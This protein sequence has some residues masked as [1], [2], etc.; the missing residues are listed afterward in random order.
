MVVGSCCCSVVVED[1]ASMVWLDL[2]FLLHSCCV[3]A[4]STEDGDRGVGSI[5]SRR[6]F[7]RGKGNHRCSKKE[8]LVYMKERVNDIMTTALSPLLHSN[9]GGDG[10]SGNSGN[11]SIS[12]GNSGGGDSDEQSGEHAKKEQ[13]APPP[14]PQQRQP[15]GNGHVPL[16]TVDPA[17]SYSIGL[18]G[19]PNTG[20][21]SV[22]N[23]LIGKKVR[24]VWWRER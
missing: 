13:F 23:L 15:M 19:Q 12:G 4:L 8:R 18:I 11:S 16:G 17:T 22:L 2:L 6:K 1:W 9:D 14:P 5:T 24:Y 7:V 10:N 21:S 20:K 3:C